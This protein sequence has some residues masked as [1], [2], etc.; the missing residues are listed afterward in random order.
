[1]SALSPGKIFMA[2]QRGLTQTAGLQRYS[3]F[4]FGKYYNEHKQPT[5]S[6][7]VF[8]DETLAGLQSVET[9]VE[10][11]SYIVIIPVTGALK[12][13]S[14]HGKKGMLDVGEIYVSKVSAQSF[15]K[16]TN[17]YEDDWVNYLQF[18]I[19]A[20]LS[21]EADFN[22]VF[23]F[24]LETTPNYLTKVISATAHD[25]PFSV[26]I[27]RFAGREEAIYNPQAGS[28]VFTFAL[29][30]AFEIQGRLL[31]ERDGLAL[32]DTA[33]V[34]LEALSNNA[35]MLIVETPVTP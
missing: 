31:H 35:L 17:P 16:I 7:C 9:V 32:W 18:H 14:A 4:N 10:Q 26:N 21:A 11:P 20:P 23:S 27:G 28:Q 24:D 22:K 33:E 2:D 34:D 13:A 1:M 12:Y 15:I 3:T 5:G 30:G 25:L 19:K 29:A 6:L 8:N